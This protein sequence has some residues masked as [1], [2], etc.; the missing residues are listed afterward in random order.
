MKKLTFAAF[1]AVSLVLGASA[2]DYLYELDWLQGPGN[3]RFLTDFTPTLT[4]TCIDAKVTF[5]EV[6]TAATAQSVFCARGKTTSTS[7][8][9]FFLLSTTKPRFDYGSDA[10][11]GTIDFV[12]TVGE[13]VTITTVGPRCTVTDDAGTDYVKEREMGEGAAGGALM[14]FA[15]YF[16]GTT[17]N[18]SN[19]GTF[20]LHHFRISSTNNLPEDAGGAITLK[21][22]YMPV[23]GLDGKVELYDKVNRKLLAPTAGTF[24][25]G[26]LK[27]GQL[28]VESDGLPEAT[29]MVVAADGFSPA[30]GYHNDRTVG[31]TVEF[32]A[33]ADPFVLN[34]LVTCRVA[35]YELYEID[36]A[37]HEETLFAAD[38]GAEVDYVY[39]ADKT[40]KIV[41]KFAY[42]VV[43]E[44]DTLELTGNVTLALPAGTTA[45]V[46]QV[47][48]TA[49]ATITKTG[50]GVLRFC[51]ISNTKAKLDL[52]GGRVCFFNIDRPD[53]TKAA[54]FAVDA[55][56]A[57]TLETEWANGVEYV[58]KVKDANGGPIY[59]VN[60]TTE[61][62]MRTDP[63][64]RRV[65]I[66]QKAQNGRNVLDFGFLLMHK[67]TNETALAQVY[68][69]ALNWNK[70]CTTVREVVQVYADR[71]EVR[72]SVSKY[73]VKT[74]TYSGPAFICDSSYP[75]TRGRLMTGWIGLFYD[76]SQNDP[77]TE[78]D[79]WI[80]GELVSD[81]SR[82][83]VNTHLPAGFNRIDS[84]STG[85]V[86]SNAFGHGRDRD[87]G[88]PYGGMMIAEYYCFTNELT[89]ADRVALDRYLAVKWDENGFAA[90]TVADGTTIEV[91]DDVRVNAASLTVNGPAVVD[92]TGELVA[93][94]VTG[95][96][97]ALTV[98]K[99]RY[100]LDPAV[101]K[102]PPSLSFP[103][104]G[105][106]ENADFA[107]VD[108]LAANG[109]LVKSGAGD[110]FLADLGADVTSFTI[111]GGAVTFDPLLTPQ[112]DVRFDAS[113]TNSLEILVENGTNYVTRWNDAAGGAKYATDNTTTNATYR[114]DTKRHT[115]YLNWDVAA[116]GLPLM[117]F[118]YL[119]MH[120][121]NDAKA[122]ALAHGGAMTW[123]AGSTC[124]EI[125]SVMGDRSE[126][127]TVATEF[128]KC[129]ESAGPSYIANSGSTYFCRRG[130]LSGN[131]LA[132]DNGQNDR[133][134]PEGSLIRDGVSTRGVKTTQPAGLHVMDWLISGDTADIPMTCTV[135][136]FAHTGNDSGTWGGL[137][138]GEYITFPRR[139]SSEDRALF[140]ET[141]RVKWYGQA[142]STRTFEN[143]TVGADAALKVTYS[144]LAVTDTLS[145]GGPLTCPE[146]SAA[147]LSLTG[148][149][150][151]EAVTTL[152]EGMTLEVFQ[153]GE[154]AAV[155]SL[156][157]ADL[158]LPAAG[159]VRLTVA[160]AKALRGIRA[161]IVDFETVD[162]SLDGWTIESNYDAG[163]SVTLEAD[164]IYAAF[165]K[166]GV[167]VLIK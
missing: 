1:A 100:V 93:K 123:S 83:W 48:G 163:V 68:G 106:F 73:G 15:S 95:F 36:N 75:G 41:W 3:G 114:L 35:G 122:F 160:N 120:S 137:Y 51:A 56:D 147:N 76:N 162:G 77:W 140:Y 45:T 63:A 18:L 19:Y 81:T 14:L 104:D 16:N 135:N 110:M 92:G 33:P 74:E 116:T 152:G 129:A 52:Q 71:P 138:I 112:I 159:T 59:A 34:P 125:F 62:T 55:S 144:N 28:E 128:P 97:D 126:V 24:A 54:W 17:K 121:Y 119:M 161:K 107:R 29:A 43:A 11:G 50:D 158:K 96:A 154:T 49:A 2:R 149:A 142:R 23:I 132:W 7:T 157:I 90:I 94:A 131:W 113:D 66:G 124:E 117:D 32:R 98:T 70:R 38:E 130:K 166:P 146:V 20:R 61:T 103:A 5:T 30:L 80:N 25:A 136:S 167:M 141:M 150:S 86:G 12:P 133:V 165:G 46:Y 47:S 8:Y 156:K 115:P 64:N 82:W 21:R 99:G 58:T 145:L 111:E 37:T 164:G 148:P 13:P 108:T 87:A 91:A 4:N 27:A 88:A 67:Y 105:T 89:T 109:T 65:Y 40:P 78:G 143:L 69:G 22:D 85:N 53:C 60:N 127:K 118:G 134:R 10:S 6:S 155:G 79:T 39:K 139:L 84:R 72:E 31:E 42:D 151:I 153:I 44:M 101:S 26:P 102:T 9:T 57:S